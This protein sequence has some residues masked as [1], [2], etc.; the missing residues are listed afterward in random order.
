MQN[1]FPD[2]IFII[3]GCGGH[4]RSVADVA[5]A[6][7]Y[8]QLY[9]I[10][11]QAQVGETIFGQPVL[12][13]LSEM[14][15]SNHLYHTIIALGNN[16]N[17][18]KKFDELKISKIPQSI[19]TLISSRA[20]VGKGAQIS[21]GTFVAHGAHVGPLSY[22]AEN[23]IINTNCL[24]EHEVTIG[25]HTH[26]SINSTVAGRCKIGNFVMLGAGA[27]VIDGIEIC[28]QVVIGAGATV[29]EDIVEPGTYVGVPAKKL[30]VKS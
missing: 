13:Q 4:S 7:G 24:I 12:A 26:I 1:V 14:Q 23:S 17:R 25:S 3:Y 6:N 19:I 9:F 5:L 10:D 2:K 21:M 8:T 29:V 20:Y 30:Q 15:L 16:F 11:P 18:A 27:T 22:I 28:D